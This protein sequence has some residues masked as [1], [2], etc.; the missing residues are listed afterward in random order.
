MNDWHQQKKAW[1][2]DKLG[3]SESGLSQEQ[4][5]MILEEKGPNVLQEGKKKST[6]QVFLSQF[7]DL[8]DRKSVV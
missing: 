7:A 5:A 4:A 1:I 8:L 3:T 2:L 6:L